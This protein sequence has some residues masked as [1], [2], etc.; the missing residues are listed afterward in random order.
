MDGGGRRSVAKPALRVAF[1]GGRGVVSKY[2]GI[3]TFYEEAG[4]RL[5]EKGHEVTVYCRKHFTP[6]LQKYNGMRVVR[7]PAMHSKHLET[8]THTA[9]STIHALWSG[10]DIV[11]YQALGSALFSGVPRMFGKKTIVTVQGLDWRRKKWGWLASTILRLGEHA[12][13][14]FPN[15]TMV[16]SK[17]LRQHYRDEHGV[18]TTFLYSQWDQ[19]PR[20]PKTVPDYPLGDRARPTIHPLS[21]AI[22]AGEELPSFNRSLRKAEYLG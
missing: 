10:C 8:L 3:E 1:I 11:H 9:L 22:L 4:R 13:A 7:L 12:S 2:S 19:P 5:A 20:A 18:P 21:R 16:V 17:T 14:H 6:P 15:T